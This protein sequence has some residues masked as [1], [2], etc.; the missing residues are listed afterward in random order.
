VTP[1][2]TADAGERAVPGLAELLRLRG[3]E[4]T[5]RAALSR[6]AAFLRG[7]TLIVNLPGSPAAVREGLEVL[8]PLLPHAAAVAAGGGHAATPGG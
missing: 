7:P 4:R 3:L 8:L 1:E 5:P 2:A 6:G